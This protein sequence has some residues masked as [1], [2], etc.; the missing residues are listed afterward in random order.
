MKH[1]KLTAIVTVNGA[2]GGSPGSRIPGA[3]I[4]A[5]IARHGVKVEASDLVVPHGDAIGDALL[6]RDITDATFLAPFFQ[7]IA[8]WYRYTLHTWERPENKLGLGAKAHWSDRPM[9]AERV[10]LF[11]PKTLTRALCECGQQ[12]RRSITNCGH[13][14]W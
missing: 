9:P 10:A 5:V 1:A 6:S 12:H 2:K 4:A 3:D 8:Q 14:D 11:H 13:S 7:Q